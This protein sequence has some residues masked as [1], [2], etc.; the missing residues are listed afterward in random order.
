MITL[1]ELFK[2]TWDI[3]EVNITARAPD[4]SFIHEWI[5]GEHVKESIH[6]RYDREDGKL[7]IRQEK[8]QYHGEQTRGGPEM[9]WGV[10]EKLFPPEL[11]DA[12]VTVLN[13]HPM[14]CGWGTHV[15]ADV[16]LQPLT[17]AGLPMES[18]FR[19]DKND[20]KHVT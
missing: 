7:T 4:L 3:A 11:I 2:V 20:K 1:R 14:C 19:E 16:E 6:Q 12:P 8:I 10:N 5:F 15:R 13:M 17:A 18:Y 9:G